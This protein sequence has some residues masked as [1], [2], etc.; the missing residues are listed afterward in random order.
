MSDPIIDLLQMVSRSSFPR[1][2]TL[3]AL[4][5]LLIANG[6]TVMHAERDRGDG[7][8]VHYGD[9]KQPW[10]TCLEEGW[11]V[12]GAVFSILRYVRRTKQPVRDLQAAK[13][14]LRWL[15]DLV[16]VELGRKP[17]ELIGAA[18]ATEAY[19]QLVHNVLTQAELDLLGIT[20]KDM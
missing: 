9:G 13:V 5:S 4:Q 14:Y 2:P 7:R 20:A 3:E 19:K 17:G 1:A 11:A 18:G 12:G 8:K 6:L 16:D 15:Q 10:D